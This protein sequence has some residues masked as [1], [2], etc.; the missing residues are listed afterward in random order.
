MRHVLSLLLLAMTPGVQAG[1]DTEACAAKLLGVDASRVEAVVP[2]APGARPEN[3]I[4]LQGTAR[5]GRF[6]VSEHT[7]V[8]AHPQPA[9]P[10][11]MPMHVNLLAQMQVRPFGVDERV[12]ASLAGGVLEL[13][14]SAGDK[15]AGVLLSGPWKMPA[16]NA[17]LR[18]R[19][20]GQ[21]TFQ[22]RVADEA[23]ARRESSLDAGAFNAAEGEAALPVPPRL[24]RARWRQFV[25]NCPSGDAK[26]ALSSLSLEPVPGRAGV[27]ATWIWNAAAWQRDPVAL[28]AWARASGIGLLFITVPQGPAGVRERERLVRFVQQAHAQHVAVWSVDGD[29]HMVLPAEH[30]ATVRRV[31]AYAGYNRT[32]PPDARLDGIQF[33]IEPYLLRDDEAQHDAGYLALAHKL[34]AAA[35]D[36]K[37]EFVVPFWWSDRTDLLAGLARDADGLAVMDYRTDP[38]QVYDFAAPF[39]DWAQANGKTVR[40]A[41]E[42]GPIATETQRRY[43]RT[44]GA[45]DLL[46]VRAGERQLLVALHAPLAQL[47]EGAQGYRLGGVRELDGS[48]TS[49]A[50]D[51]ARLHALLPALE[52]DFS[53]WPGFAGMAVHGLR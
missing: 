44:D 52:E 31:Q 13:S 9:P 6:I 2:L 14:C 33:D 50:T 37:L 39:L 45:A 43:H 3:T 23:Q 29:P 26:L 47:P 35:R 49:F 19:A 38:R 15:P 28:L 21:G 4:I 40:I 16:A 53:A 8:P 27:R 24:D 18:L 41:L 42:A 32:A 11:P 30:A 5:D 12:H 48:A 34:R 1:C 22:L 17:M 36:L 20:A 51:L 7:L 46:L 10:E 25:I